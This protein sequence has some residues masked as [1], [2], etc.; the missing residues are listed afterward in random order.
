MPALQVV[1]I[2]KDEDANRKP[3]NNDMD[4][5][6]THSRNACW[7]DVDWRHDLARGKFSFWTPLYA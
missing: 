6:Q 5:S 4:G 2:N 7:V 1:S 3:A